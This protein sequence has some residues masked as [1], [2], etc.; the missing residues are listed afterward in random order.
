[1][2]LE[3]TF[4]L[5]PALAATPRTVEKLSGGLTNHNLKVTTPDGVFVARCSRSDTTLL[6]I[7]RHGEFHNTWVAEQSGVGA[8]FVDFRPDLGVLV[9]T[10]LEGRT[11]T[12]ENLR[13]PGM[14]DRLVRAMRTLHDGA[15]FVGEFDMFGRQA[16][17][18]TV[19]EERG[20]S[21]PD[22]YDDHAA[23]FARIETAL[24]QRRVAPKPCNND[25][26]AGNVVDDGEK[27]WLIDY[28]YSGQGDPFFEIGNTWTECGLDDDHLAELVTSYVGHH[29][30]GL[31]ARARLRA[32][33]SRYGWALWGSIQAATLED[34]FD[35]DQWGAERFELAVADF[36]DPDF[37]HWLDIA[38]G[39]IA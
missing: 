1:M 39:A 27:L 7:D 9:I 36:T 12:N 13:E 26:L 24:A 19:C 11:C 25:L 8:P 17:Y 2:S 21:I 32:T 6:G 29:D 15:A 4:D 16:A 18:R 14:I 23:D 37:E 5:I 38:A 10:Y 34:D 33:T 3:E 35:F 22:G 28:E 30:S 31:L 20:F